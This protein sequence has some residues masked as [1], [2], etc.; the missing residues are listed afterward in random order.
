METP[1]TAQKRKRD[2]LQEPASKSATETE[3]EATGYGGGEQDGTPTKRLKSTG[4][5]EQVHKRKENG[6]LPSGG[7]PVDRGPFKRRKF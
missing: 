4:T 6:T 5:F 1:S 7:Q 2:A 3:E